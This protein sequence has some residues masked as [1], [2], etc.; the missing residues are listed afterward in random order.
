MSEIALKTIQVLVAIAI[1][2]LHSYENYVRYPLSKRIF[3]LFAHSPNWMGLKG[4]V[5]NYW[6]VLKE[7]LSFINIDLFKLTIANSNELTLEYSK[8]GCRYYW[9]LQWL[10]FKK[11]KTSSLILFVSAS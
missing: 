6:N 2:L 11:Y 9:K 10:A 5:W 7:I 4:S 8:K 3:I 1:S